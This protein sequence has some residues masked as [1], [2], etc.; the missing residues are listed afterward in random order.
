[1]E[2]KIYVVIS[3]DSDGK[4]QKSSTSSKK[5][6]EMICMCLEVIHGVGKYEVVSEEEFA[7]IIIGKSP[8]KV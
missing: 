4:I 7:L 6:A 2:N 3:R 5:D 1:M 8:T